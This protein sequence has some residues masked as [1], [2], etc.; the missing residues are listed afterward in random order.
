M[1]LTGSRANYCLGATVTSSQKVVYFIRDVEKL[2]N[3]QTRLWFAACIESDDLFAL[4]T[5]LGYFS[6]SSAATS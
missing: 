3:L 6:Y 2:C 1:I 5:A 4:I